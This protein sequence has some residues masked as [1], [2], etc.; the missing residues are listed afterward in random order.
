VTSDHAAVTH[1]F[2]HAPSGVR[3]IMAATLVTTDYVD[4]QKLSKA[5]R[6]AW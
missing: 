3:P 1:R 4:K 2:D 6:P 5:E